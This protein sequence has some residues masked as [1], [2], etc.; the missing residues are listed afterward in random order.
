LLVAHRR[1]VVDREEQID[2]R[3][4]DERFVRLVARTAAAAVE[5]RR[6]AI[7]RGGLR[8]GRVVVTAMKKRKSKKRQEEERATKIHSHII[9]A[10]RAP[11]E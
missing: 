7:A 2:L 1:R 9:E 3:R 11:V 10:T 6:T 4:R 5:A 8:H